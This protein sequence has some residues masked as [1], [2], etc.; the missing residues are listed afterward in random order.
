MRQRLAVNL[1]ATA[2]TVATSMAPPAAAI[3]PLVVRVS[4]AEGAPGEVVTVVFRTYAARALGQ[5]QI[6][7]R[8]LN[9]GVQQQRFERGRL[10]GTTGPFVALEGFVAFSTVGDAI[11]AGVL[12][13]SGEVAMLGFTSASGTV[14]QID[15]P[16]GAI[17]LRLA[18]DVVPGAVYTL[19]L[20][21]PNT[22]LND[23]SGQ[24]V[25][26]AGKSGELA[27]TPFG[28]ARSLAADGD[29]VPPGEFVHFGLQT[30]HPFSIG[31]GTVVINWSPGFTIGTPIVRMDQRHGASTGTVD[32]AVPNQVTVTFASA[33]GS[34]NSVVPGDLID[35][36]V[37]TDPTHPDALG[38][39]A[40]VSS[41]L[42]DPQDGLIATLNEGGELEIERRDAIFIDS[43]EAGSTIY[44]TAVP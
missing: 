31:S 6:C 34:L 5:G 17:S 30:L 14:N 20:D 21:L 15:G 19:E 33:D 24:P 16:I 27:I 22:G 35:I 7:F 23:P 36:M 4:D 3:E 1:L 42:R 26:I 9:N 29:R 25:V 2:L 28:Q 41:E 10:V 37:Q 18:E 13:P 40:I 11:A 32:V 39:V 12:E 38:V 44:W 43:F 8:V